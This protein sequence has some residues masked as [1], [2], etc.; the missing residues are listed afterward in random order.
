MTPIIYKMWDNEASVNEP[1]PRLELYTPSECK[2]D[3]AILLVP[4]S[5]YRHS[6]DLPI[7][8]GARV[9]ESLAGRGINV[10]VLIYRVGVGG[11]YPEPLLD[12]RRAV[13]YLRHN[14]EKFGISPDKIIT[15]GYSAGG[16]LCASLVSYH[17]ELAGEGVDEIDDASYMPNYQAL[18][19]PVIS[20]DKTRR[21]TNCG[22]VD[23]LLGEGG[24]HLADALSFE[25]TLSAPVPPTF[26]FHNFDD[27]AVG[28]ENTLLYAARLAE[29]GT[30]T[31]IHIYPDG[32]HGVGLAVDDKKSSL[33]NRDWLDRF[34]RWLS[35]YDLL[36][37]GSV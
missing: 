15:L 30:P 6:P 32:G 37:Y 4:G 31:E 16:H 7:Q 12:G 33:H 14:A 25:K 22:S 35:Y 27:R 36:P 11:V 1:V 5:A 34:V 9:A 3:A 13:R 10:F 23:N 24:M 20:F 21:Y 28:V 19:Y 2:T 17:E 18:C 26:L 29:I 8:E